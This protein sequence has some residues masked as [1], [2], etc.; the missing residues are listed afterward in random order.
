MS[1][2][3]GHIM[4]LSR[5]GSGATPPVEKVMLEAARIAGNAPHVS[6]PKTP[7]L[8]FGMDPMAALAF[9]NERI[10][11]LGKKR[12]RGAGLRQDSH[13]MVAAVFSF[14]CRPAEVES[15][16]YISLRDASLAWFK[17]EIEAL[18]G[19]ILGAVQH[20]DETYLHVHVYAMNLGNPRLN[21]KMLHRGHVAA[22]DAKSQG[23]NPTDDY[24]A[25]M[26]GWQNDYNKITARFG[27]TKIG[28]GRRRLSRAQHKIET[29]E[30]A[31]HADRIFDLEQKETQLRQRAIEL[32]VAESRAAE[33]YE[34]ATAQA[35]ELQAI[36]TGIKAWVADELD[37]DA[38]FTPG[39]I[40]S[41][42]TQIIAAIMPARATV[43]ALI[44]KIGATA[45]SLADNFL[46]MTYRQDIMHVADRIDDITNKKASGPK[47]P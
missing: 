5:R 46:Q 23:R 41:R 20:V 31:R 42:R 4:T 11:S 39:V 18:D 45:L 19:K 27:L 1:Y 38:A 32:E 25:A 29:A 6:D 12:G 16:Y 24:K 34:I 36:S 28:P 33:A 47:P 7:D 22:A 3:F 2:Q 13:T 44:I 26:R 43:I 14:P 30:A 37:N 15:E 35:K 10:A 9:H 21:A 40:K 17:S 8:L